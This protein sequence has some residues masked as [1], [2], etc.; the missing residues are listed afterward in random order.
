MRPTT[1]SAVTELEGQR[2]FSR[3]G[4]KRGLDREEVQSKPSGQPLVGAA[5][6][7][8]QGPCDSRGH[9]PVA[10][11][12]VGA[13]CQQSASPKA[14]P[15]TGVTTLSPQDWYVRLVK[16]QCWTRSDSALLEGAELVNRL[17][18]RDMSE[19]LRH[20]VRRNLPLS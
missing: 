18:P 19:F 7:A 15:P 3:W 12:G 13:H 10:W 5:R 20:P 6:M 17:P 8:S 2:P 11:A 9:C 4:G 16:S 1:L 14:L